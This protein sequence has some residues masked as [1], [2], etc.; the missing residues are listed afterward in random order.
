MAARVFTLG[1]PLPGNA[2]EYAA[3]KS[4][5]SLFDA[6][7]IVFTPTF[8][9]YNSSESYAGK[10]L[11]SEG[12]SPHLINDCAHW[13]HEIEVAVE[14]GKVVFV[15]LVKPDEVYYDTGQRTYSATGWSRVTTR[16][17][18]SAS[19]Y[20]SL[21]LRLEG[22]VPKG[23]TEIYSRRGKGLGYNVRVLK[24]LWGKA[25]KAQPMV[26]TTEFI[27]GKCQGMQTH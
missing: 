14:A 17:V 2:G 1:R 25:F 10:P 7:V 5:K 6:D 24:S 8:D 15:M 16:Q 27:D 4:D 20:D 21:P 13:R 19:S 26:S 12:D 22:L 9:D 18:A 11:I 23:D 3:F